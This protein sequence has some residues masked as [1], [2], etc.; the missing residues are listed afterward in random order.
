MDLFGTFALL[1]AAA[2]VLAL[3]FG[4]SAMASSSAVGNLRSEQWMQRRVAFQ[5][6]ALAFILIAVLTAG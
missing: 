2:A 4:V 6:A 5:A 1:A 3:V